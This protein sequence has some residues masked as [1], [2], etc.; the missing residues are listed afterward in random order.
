MSRRI[1]VPPCLRTRA[2]WRGRP[3]PERQ[4]QLH[5][6]VALA[7]LVR[8]PHRSPAEFGRSARPFPL[9]PRANKTVLRSFGTIRV[10][11]RLWVSSSRGK[12]T[13]VG[14]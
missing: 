9:S 7:R 2:N 12:P 13:T 1:P 8:A 6:S 14:A 10:P 3:L 4:Q 5:F 11:V